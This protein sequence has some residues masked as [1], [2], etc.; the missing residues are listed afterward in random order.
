MTEPTKRGKRVPMSARF[1]RSAR[2]TGSEGRPHATG[3]NDAAGA[4]ATRPGDATSRRNAGNDAT[5]RGVGGAAS[6]DAS[7]PLLDVRGLRVTYGRGARAVPAV[8]GVDL[9]LRAGEKLGIA[10]ESGCGKSTLAMALLRLL[11]PGATLEGDIL[12]DGEDIRTM[13]WGRLRAVRWAGA[14][15]VFQGAMHSLNAV[16]RVGDQILEPILLHRLAGPAE[17][18]RRVKELLRHVGLPVSRAAAYPHELSGGQRQR[19]M[20]AM[21]LA[22]DPRL[23]IADEPTTALD[24]M[25]QAQ[26]LRLI[27]GLVAKKGIG[28]VMISHD[29]AVLADT[30]DRLAIMYAGRVVE[31][32]PAR[33]VHGQALHPY[34]AALS[35]AFPRIGDPASRFSPRG[36][37]GDPPDPAAL[38]TGCTFHPRC[39][40]ALPSCA[41]EPQPLRVAGPGR[42]A[43]CVRVEEGFEATSREKTVRD[44][45]AGRG[46][47][48]SHDGAADDATSRA[49][50]AGGATSPAEAGGDA[51][52][53]HDGAADDATLRTGDHATSP[54]DGARDPAD[55]A[56]DTAAGAGD[57]GHGG[58][59]EARSKQA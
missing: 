7:R 45:A 50:V 14:S 23:I 46:D 27:E 40:V 4:G 10:G 32:G 59:D 48:A 8:R 58:A 42:R 38:P 47:A 16:H 30:C 41:T 57:A 28:L 43:A 5:S 39:P 35:G 11:P 3:R 31:E 29:L 37:P 18:R 34:G 55:G 9:S 22:C 15:I 53:P 44:D 20:I 13:A 56:R 6:G 2:A 51:A 36:L 25:I 17:G 1:S 19:V 49:G 54:V 24:V 12:L 52:S 26:I 21:A 33:D